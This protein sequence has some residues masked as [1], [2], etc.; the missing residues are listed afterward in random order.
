MEWEAEPNA[1]GF[2]EK[3]GGRFVRDGE[4]SAWGRVNAVLGIDL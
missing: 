3:M 4:P 2:Y 1:I